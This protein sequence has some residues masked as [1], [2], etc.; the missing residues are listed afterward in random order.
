[1]AHTC[2]MSYHIIN[3]SINHTP[4]LSPR[5]EMSVHAEGHWRITSYAQVCTVCRTVCTF[6][7]VLVTNDERQPTDVGLKPH[8][9]ASTSG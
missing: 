9:D 3:Q 4:I 5:T 2:F 8:T 1:M 6:P 7:V